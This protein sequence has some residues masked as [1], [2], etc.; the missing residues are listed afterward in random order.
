MW[1][2]LHVAAAK[3][4]KKG[5]KKKKKKHSPKV[6]VIPWSYITTYTTLIESVWELFPSIYISASL[7]PLVPGDAHIWYKDVPG[8]PT[9]R[10]GF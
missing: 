8:T 1:N 7:C 9:P 2:E 10:V 4:R 3:G 6:S 5:K